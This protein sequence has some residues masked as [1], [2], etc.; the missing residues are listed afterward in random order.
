MGIEICE[1]IAEA[2]GKI[3]KRYRLKTF[4]HRTCKKKLFWCRLKYADVLVPLLGWYPSWELW[5]IH[6]SVPLSFFA[7]FLLFFHSLGPTGFL[8]R[9]AGNGNGRF[10]HGEERRI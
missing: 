2:I 5:V 4:R 3:E 9:S 6:L 8:D 7:A 1:F 10:K